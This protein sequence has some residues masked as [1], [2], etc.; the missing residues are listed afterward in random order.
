MTMARKRLFRIAV[1]GTLGLPVL[2]FLLHPYSRQSIFG[3]KIADVPLCYWQESFRHHADGDGNPDSVTLKMLRWL[4]FNQRDP[5]RGLPDKRADL[6]PLLLSLA[7]DPQPRVR[8]MVAHHFGRGFTPDACAPTLLR[9]LDDPDPRVRRAA[10]GT[11]GGVRPEV[12]AALPRLL[13]LLEDADTG[14]RV[15]AAMA[16]SRMGQKQ[17]KAVVAI[18]AQALSDS[19]W[20]F[21]AALCLDGM[22]DDAADAFP[23]LAACATTHPDRHTQLACVA[24]SALAAD[25]PSPSSGSCC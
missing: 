5:A 22:G 7:D 1:Y 19:V 12:M 20:H 4:G 15:Q 9:M 16:L 11:I 14:C 3:P 25:L 6:L 21:D 10:A 18:L 13:E 24:H 17:H 2:L 8:E 23:E